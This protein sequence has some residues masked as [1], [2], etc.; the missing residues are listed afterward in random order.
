MTDNLFA[1]IP[2]SSEYKDICTEISN[3]I[4]EKMPNCT[5]SKNMEYSK[6][7]ETR[8]KKMRKLGF[9]NIIKISSDDGTIDVSMNDDDINSFE[10]VNISDFIDLIES[11]EPDNNSNSEEDEVNSKNNDIKITK[12]IDDDY[13]N[14]NDN[15]IIC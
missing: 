10:N 9:Y 13:D 1:I 2:L 4:S 11:Y 8:M 6:S 5:I 14:D 7:F 3:K 15:C 12:K